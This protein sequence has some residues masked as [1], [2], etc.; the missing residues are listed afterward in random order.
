MLASFHNAST[1]VIIILINH[2][3]HKMS[4]NSNSYSVYY[5][6]KQNEVANSQ[7][8]SWNQRTFDIFLEKLLN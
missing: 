4:E 1:E 8:R 3:V 2:L 5:H 7:L 6:I